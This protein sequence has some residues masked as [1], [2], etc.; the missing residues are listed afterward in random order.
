MKAK[1]MTAAQMSWNLKKG[2]AWENPH[3]DGGL[4]D[5]FITRQHIY[6]WEPP[7]LDADRNVIDGRFVA[8]G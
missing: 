3:N 5:E 1:T 4:S 7:H 6:Q 8:I 2:Y